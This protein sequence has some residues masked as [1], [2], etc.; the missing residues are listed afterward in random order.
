M[1]PIQWAMSSPAV[2]PSSGSRPDLGHVSQLVR[3]RLAGSHALIL[4]SNYCPNM[5]LKGS[6]PEPVKQRI[7]GRQGH[8]S[9]AD[10]NSLLADLIHEGLRLVVLAHISEENNEYEHARML[11]S[12]VLRGHDIALHVAR[13]GEP[14]PVF[15]VAP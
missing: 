12:Q 4:E 15:T 7:R 2:G 5:L 1:P 13:Q 6:Y 14:T 3:Q 11:A 10:S 9:N 8:L